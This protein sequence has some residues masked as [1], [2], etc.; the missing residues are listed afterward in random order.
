VKLA[1]A[2]GV[3]LMLGTLTKLV[4]ALN[5]GQESAAGG[6]GNQRAIVLEVDKRQLGKTMIDILE[7]KYS[8]RTD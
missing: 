8:L 7:D 3:T 6:G 2:L 4:K 5:A 1:G